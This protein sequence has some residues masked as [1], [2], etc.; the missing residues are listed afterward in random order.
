MCTAILC[1]CIG[2][3]CANRK[4]Y[5]LYIHLLKVRSYLNTFTQ[6]IYTHKLR[7]FANKLQYACSC[8]AG[9]LTLIQRWNN[10]MP[11]RWNDVEFWLNMKVE[12]TLK[13]WRWFN[14]DIWR[15]FNV[16]LTSSDV[17]TTFKF[18]WYL[19]EM[20]Q[21]FD[22][23]HWF[24][25]ANCSESFCLKLFYEQHDTRTNIINQFIQERNS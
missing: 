21:L 14:V 4:Q 19:V 24:F 7:H 22:L 25:F 2:W 5:F 12:W 10:V 16:D 20:L 1:V 23:E 11:Q 15:C 13:F 6:N 8:P 9:I 18:S 3:T 17:V